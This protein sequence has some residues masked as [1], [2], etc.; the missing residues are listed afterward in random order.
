MKKWLQ[1]LLM[2]VGI[3]AAGTIAW[4]LFFLIEWLL[5]GWGLTICVP[6]VT[7]VLYIVL[8]KKLDLRFAAKVNAM[9]L[10]VLSV[11]M[12]GASCYA[13]YQMFFHAKREGE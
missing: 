9:I 1:V 10:I 6:A 13:I 11:L 7:I 2:Y 12:L 5:N 4:L 3:P 8:R